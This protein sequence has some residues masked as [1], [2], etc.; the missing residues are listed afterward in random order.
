MTISA[1]ASG[2]IFV[3]SPPEGRDR[4]AH[5]GEIDDAWHTGEVLHD[6]A[7]RRVNMDLGVRLRGRVPPTEGR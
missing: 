1:G 4:F 5:R 2:L 3:G 7:C 6:H